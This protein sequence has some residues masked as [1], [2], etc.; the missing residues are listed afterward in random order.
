MLYQLLTDLVKVQIEHKGR[1]S[2]SL[3]KDRM[4]STYEDE[5]DEQI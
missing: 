5:V 2:H 1:N 4:Y 3:N